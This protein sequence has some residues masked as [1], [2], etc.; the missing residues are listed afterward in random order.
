MASF[1]DQAKSQY[2]TYPYFAFRRPAELAGGSQLHPVAIVG[3]GPV[4]VAAALELA[5]FGVASV[6]I[7]AD[8]T[9]AEGSRAIC[10]SRRT[11]EILD[12][13]G[14]AAAVMEK[15]LPWTHG[16]SFYKDKP[17][18]RLEMPHG[19]DD[20][21]YPMVNLQQCYL[22][23][24]LID[25]AAAEPLI[26]IRW[27]SRVVGL[28][29]TDDDV[30]LD[31]ETPEGRYP[32]RACYVIAADG[33][34]SV[35]RQLLGLSLH[36]QSYEGRY[37]IADIVL[38]SDYPTERRAWFDPPSNPGSTVLM[39]KQPDDIW[40]IDYQL[41]D[42]EDA[43]QELQE[44]RIRQRITAHLAFIG[45]TK[46]WQLDWFSLY[47][48]HSLCL[49]DY[50]KGRVIFAGDA[51]H[52]VPIFGVRGLN[53]GI[54]DANN[55]GWKLA[56]V[57]EGKAPP[58]LLQ[59]YGQERRA[60][61]FDVF[62]NAGKSTLFMTPPSRGYAIMRE[63]ALRLAVDQ[64]LTRPLI[65]PRQSQPF[66]YRDSALNTPD[67][68]AFAGGPPPGA[69]PPGRHFADGGYLCDLIGRTFTLLAFDD[70]A[71]DY[72]GPWLR[73]HAEASLVVLAAVLRPDFGAAPLSLYLLRPDGHVAA[74]FKNY[75]SLAALDVAL[76][77][78]QG[79]A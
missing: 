45:E 16:T 39:H 24:F 40:R 11:L 36:G 10:F 15:A 58:A 73:A 63:A 75:P 33:A 32:L 21:F 44:T 30:T 54:A 18:F 43:A 1:A 61:T 41:R 46:P 2:F 53:S 70:A 48:A 8:D 37:L 77:R 31:I 38:K 3:G 19:V 51:A 66:Y 71:R 42:D 12:G 5:R 65:N 62:A 28:A 52:L 23:K 17:V 78:A 50:V 74:R 68:G 35:M 79:H 6:V 47:K 7:E 13:L 64:P 72:L 60:A 67:D 69:L 14:V 55:L 26:D 29:L 27:Q 4:G 57:I 56:L 22:E 9:L 34:R 25:R 76:R 49:D 59:S 20:K